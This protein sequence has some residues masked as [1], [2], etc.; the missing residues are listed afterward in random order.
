MGRIRFNR[1][2][3]FSTVLN[4]TGLTL[5]FSIFMTVMVQVLY[6]LRYDRCYPEH[7]KVCE[8]VPIYQRGIAA[9]QKLFKFIYN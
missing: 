2:T 6:D 8:R 3:L 5:A 4:V 1:H 9:F 7:E